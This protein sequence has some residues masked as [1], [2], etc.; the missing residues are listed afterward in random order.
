MTTHR[1]VSHEEWIEARRQHLAREKEFTRLRDQLSQ[2]R[3]ELPWEKVEKHYVFD[4]AQGKES[5]ADLFQG[6]RCA[7]GS[8]RTMRKNSQPDQKGPDA[9]RRPMAAR[10]AYSLYVERAA[11]G[12]NAADGPFSA[13]C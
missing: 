1:V 8:S 4:R 2:E 13:A 10:E 12:T 3:R 11:E 7:D 6:R 5:L 9:R